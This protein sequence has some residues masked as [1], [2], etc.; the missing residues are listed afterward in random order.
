MAVPE[1]GKFVVCIV[2]SG[3][4]IIEN[5]QQNKDIDSIIDI[6]ANYANLLENELLKTDGRFT[7]KNTGS[8]ILS[9]ARNGMLD[10]WSQFCEEIEKKLT[11]EQVDNLVGKFKTDIFNVLNVMKE[12]NN[13]LPT[14]SLNDFYNRF[15]SDWGRNEINTP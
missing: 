1:V 3:K 6:V 4:Q 7:E 15:N 5:W 10:I 9:T 8:L 2:I 13:G 12:L 14:K 11:I